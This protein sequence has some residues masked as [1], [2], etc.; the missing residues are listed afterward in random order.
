MNYRNVIILLVVVGIIIL[1]VAPIGFVISG[2]GGLEST[3]HS[4]EEEHDSV[5]S[6]IFPTIAHVNSYWTTDL[7]FELGQPQFRTTESTYF[8][9]IEETKDNGDLLVRTW[10]VRIAYFDLAATVRTAAPGFT[11][12]ADIDFWIELKQNDYNVFQ[13]ADEVKA[14]ILEVVTVGAAEVSSTA[15]IEVSPVAGGFSFDMDPLQSEPIPSWMADSGYQESLSNLK[16]VRIKLTVL[17][18]EPYYIPAIIRADQQ[19]TWRMEV[20][21]LVFGFWEVLSPYDPCIPGDVWEGWFPWLDDIFLG[22]QLILGGIL[23]LVI[24]VAIV[25]MPLPPTVKLIGLAVAWIVIFVIF[26]GVALIAGT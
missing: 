24:T 6:E 13:D 9:E 25:K 12:I 15:H 17:R 1:F 11:Q 10:E 5:D 22:L 18:A 3:V 8:N 20:R 4:V 14:Y 23:G 21:A 7:N 19:A 16:N 2:Y 26:G